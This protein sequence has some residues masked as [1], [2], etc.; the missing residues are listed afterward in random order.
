MRILPC[1]LPYKS[2]WLN[3]IEPKWV[4]GKK[5]IVE[6]THTLTAAQV[7]TRVCAYYGCHDLKPLKQKVA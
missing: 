3:A 7:Q 4:H 2:P 5:A 1:F 6:P